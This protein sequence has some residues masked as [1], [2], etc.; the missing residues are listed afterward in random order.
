MSRITI[1]KYIFADSEICHGKPT[2]A[3]TR[4]MVWQVLEMLADG[5]SAEEISNAFPSLNRDHIKA[6]LEYASSITQEHY[7]IV[8]T[9][10]DWA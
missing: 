4:I 1:N 5:Q 7:A 10:P 9:S 2:F 3:G 6:A 8:N